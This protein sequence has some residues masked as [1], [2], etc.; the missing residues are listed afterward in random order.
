M[1][2]NHFLKLAQKFSEGKPVIVLLEGTKYFP[3]AYK[4]NFCNGTPKNRAILMD[5]NRNSIIEVPME[6]VDECK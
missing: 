6:R 1:D 4:M 2:R 5:Q 3:V